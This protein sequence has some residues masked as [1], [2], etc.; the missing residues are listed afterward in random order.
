ML[1]VTQEPLNPLTISKNDCRPNQIKFREINFGIFMDSFKNVWT[2]L[3][4]PHEI[5]RSNSYFVLI[6]RHHSFAFIS[7]AMRY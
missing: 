1:N 7:L 3:V 4:S 2:S 6:V 5:S